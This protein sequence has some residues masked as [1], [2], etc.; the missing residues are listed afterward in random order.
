MLEKSNQTTWPASLGDKKTNHHYRERSSRDKY[1]E[2]NPP[3]GN[4]EKRS[5]N[6]LAKQDLNDHTQRNLSSSSTINIGKEISSLNKGLEI[7]YY[8]CCNLR[9][10]GDEKEDAT[11][12]LTTF[13]KNS[14][15]RSGS[16][17]LRR[18]RGWPKEVEPIYEGGLGLEQASDPFV[19]EAKIYLWGAFA[20]IKISYLELLFILRVFDFLMIFLYNLCYINWV[21]G[22]TCMV[23]FI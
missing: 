5:I 12:I 18:R 2:D 21:R 10:H 15:H 16:P 23:S 20:A 7:T 9:W 4:H 14:T 8:R 6:D 22:S 19:E 3:C 17:P 13:I 1:C 11:K